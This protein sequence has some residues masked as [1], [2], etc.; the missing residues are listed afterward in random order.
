MRVKCTITI[1]DAKFV[2]TAT[3]TDKRIGTSRMIADAIAGCLAAIDKADFEPA[4]CIVADLCIGCDVPLFADAA[5]AYNNINDFDTIEFL[6]VV[7]RDAID[8]T[9]IKMPRRVIPVHDVAAAR[10]A[11]CG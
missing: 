7:S 9:D 10:A 5:L 3:D 1:D 6:L 2:A 11:L 4:V 8:D